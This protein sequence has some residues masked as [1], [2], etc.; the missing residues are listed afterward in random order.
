MNYSEEAS[1]PSTAYVRSAISE[2]K[3]SIGEKLQGT[4]TAIV[5]AICAVRPID[6]PT[7]ACL[8]NCALSAGR[9]EWSEWFSIALLSICTLSIYYIV[10]VVRAAKSRNLIECSIKNLVGTNPENDDLL[11][12]PV[13]NSWE[14]YRYYEFV[15]YVL[16]VYEDRRAEDMADGAVGLPP[17]TDSWN[18]FADFISVA[19]D[20]LFRV[21]GIANENFADP[22]R[23]AFDGSG[24]EIEIHRPAEWLLWLYAYYARRSTPPPAVEWRGD[25]DQTLKALRSELASVGT[26][27]LG[28]PD[29]LVR[30]PG[31]PPANEAKWLVFS[32]KTRQLYGALEAFE[33]CAKSGGKAN[34]KKLKILFARSKK[35]I[36]EKSSP[37]RP[38]PADP[39]AKGAAMGKKPKS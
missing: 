29:F 20:V 16:L 22:L 39:D 25:M 31:R 30:D 9:I 11:A 8:R 12:L 10:I 27:Q 5:E 21:T 23:I 1:S 13:F 37:R 36:C 17:N 19:V 18:K 3:F 26:G 6:A 24:E 35:F 28:A 38:F 2:F 15:R 14:C 32:D 7:E 4:P 34:G 33:A